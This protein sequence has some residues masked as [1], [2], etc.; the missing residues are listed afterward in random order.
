MLANSFKISVLDE[1]AKAHPNTWW[2]IKADGADLVSGLGE[3]VK[4]VWS[5]DVDLADG[6]LAKFK[7]DHQ[8]QIDHISKLGQ[9]TSQLEITK[10]LTVVEQEVIQDA[11]FLSSSKSVHDHDS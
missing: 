2:W 3:S 4:G 5:G 6:A 7:E 9:A 8:R 1:A 10:D 11:I